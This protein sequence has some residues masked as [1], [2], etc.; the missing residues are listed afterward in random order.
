MSRKPTPAPRR[1]ETFEERTARINREIAETNRR[2]GATGKP[3]QAARRTAPDPTRTQPP[4][5]PTPTP[6]PPRPLPLNGRARDRRYEEMVNEATGDKP[7]NMAGGGAVKGKGKCAKC[8]K[9]AGSC[10][11]CKRK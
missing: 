2:T 3:M 7:R 10:A 6:T 4:P 1:A 5:R 9:A 11:M 8:G